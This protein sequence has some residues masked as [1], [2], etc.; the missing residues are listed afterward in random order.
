MVILFFLDRCYNPL[1]ETK[2]MAKYL[3]QD[4]PFPSLI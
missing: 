3:F 2:E 4:F 1:G